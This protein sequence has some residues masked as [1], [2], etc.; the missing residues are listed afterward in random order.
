MIE[1]GA[2]DQI[3]GFFWFLFFVCLFKA[4]WAPKVEF[5][6][7]PFRKSGWSSRG[8][9]HGGCNLGLASI[10]L[11]ATRVHFVHEVWRC[12]VGKF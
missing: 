12:R 10:A 6:M 3:L 8:G 1:G 5:T 11:F 9:W 4:S 7:T 2:I